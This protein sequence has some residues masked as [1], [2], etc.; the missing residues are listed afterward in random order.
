MYLI[1]QRILLMQILCVGWKLWFLKPAVWNRARYKH[2]MDQVDEFKILICITNKIPSGRNAGLKLVVIFYCNMSLNNDCKNM[3]GIVSQEYFPERSKY[4]KIWSRRPASVIRVGRFGLLLT[5]QLFLILYILSTTSHFII[6][7]SRKTW[8]CSNNTK[9]L[10][11]WNIVS[12]MLKWK[13]L[14][15]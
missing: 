12:V 3:T 15:S 5:C 2:S 1:Q 9:D 13:I 6:G 10:R 11:Q 14:V 4:Y 7:N 8:Q